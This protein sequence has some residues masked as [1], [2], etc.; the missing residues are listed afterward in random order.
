MNY[1]LSAFA[2][3]QEFISS[4]T[5]PGPAPAPS[6]R[7]KTRS[8]D[9]TTPNCTGRMP[10]AEYVTFAASV[11]VRFLIVRLRVRWQ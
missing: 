10:P 7:M 2:C 1:C 9:R 6:L 11:V 3:V 8:T 5:R 4:P